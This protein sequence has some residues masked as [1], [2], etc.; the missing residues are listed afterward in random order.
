MAYF[1]IMVRA[2]NLRGQP[3]KL[4]RLRSRFS[5]NARSDTSNSDALFT[6]KRIVGGLI[7]TCFA[8]KTFSL[9]PLLNR[10]VCVKASLNKS[11]N[12]VGD[13]LVVYRSQTS[14]MRGTMRPTFTPSLHEI[15][16][17]SIFL[18]RNSYG[19]VVSSH[20]AC[21]SVVKRSFLLR[22]IISALPFSNTYDANFNS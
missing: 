11:V 13:M 15:V 1:G 22:T 5:K 16:I 14:L 4:C 6:F 12:S 17:V 19:P 10:G 21:R 20:S 18:R 9:C 2:T 8:E 3:L 7:A